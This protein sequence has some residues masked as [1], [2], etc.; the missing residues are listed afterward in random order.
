MAV[1][2][3][4]LAQLPLVHK[5]KVRDTYDLGD[6]LLMVTTDRI[7][8]FDYV[9]PT[10]IPDRGK[11]LNSLSAF[12]FR[13]LG[14]TIPNHLISDGLEGWPE[15]L[16]ADADTL[17][18]RAMI[19][20]KAERINYECIVRGYITG[21]GWSEY[22]SQ[23]TLAG[24]PLPEGLVNGSKLPEPVFTP[25]TKNDEGHDEN[26]SV[27]QLENEAGVELANKLREV[28]IALY[29]AGLDHAESR[30]VILADTKFEFGWVNGELTLIDEA[31][32][33]D[34]SRFWLKSEYQPGGTLPSLDKQFVRDWLSQ[35]GWDKESTPPELPD[36]VVQ[37]TR[38]R[39]LE[40]YR[41]ITGKELAV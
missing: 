36:D 41:L 34:S 6:S 29:Q 31:L 5:G 28:S 12:W 19:V 2:E 37:A 10:P 33:P 24:K 20:K 18:G 3:T 15:P 13:R 9:L 8:A 35:S 40:A 22:K 21:S 26:I 32:T 39:Y 14:G 23:G 25:S 4:N 17:N 16:K 27:E 7:S 38:D 11:V 30:G 1:A